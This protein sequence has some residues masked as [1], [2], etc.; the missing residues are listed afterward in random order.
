M[1]LQM[2]CADSWFLLSVPGPPPEPILPAVPEERA[3]P[4]ATSYPRLPELLE[5]QRKGTKSPQ[6]SFNV[7]E[8]KTQAVAAEHMSN[9][10]NTTVLYARQFFAFFTVSYLF[11]PFSTSPSSYASFST[12]LQGLLS[13]ERIPVIIRFL[14]VL[15]N[16]LFKVLTQ[17]DD[18]DVTTATTR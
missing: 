9:Q 1:L 2:L 10:C 17:N 14:P 15:F 7:T 4:L 5:G 16:Q 13:M 18:D 11:P 8:T 6:F 3:G 12:V